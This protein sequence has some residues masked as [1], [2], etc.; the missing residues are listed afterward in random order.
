[1]RR[2]RRELADE[3]DVPAY[4]IF[5]DAVLREMARVVPRNLGELRGI[6][7]VGDKKLAE[8][9]ARFLEVTGA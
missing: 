2:L 3:R 1:M 8:F 4:V 5:S 9:G 6:S 7:G